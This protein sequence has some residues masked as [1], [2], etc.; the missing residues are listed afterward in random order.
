L[1]DSIEALPHGALK[2]GLRTVGK[3]MAIP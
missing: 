3:W 1:Q 2:G